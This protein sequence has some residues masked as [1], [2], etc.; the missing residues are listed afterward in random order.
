MWDLFPIRDQTCSPLKH[1]V[2]TGKCQEILALLFSF[3]YVKC[4]EFRNN[5]IGKHHSS[6]S[7]VGTSSFLMFPSHSFDVPQKYLGLF[8]SFGHGILGPQP[9]NKLVPS[10]MLGSAEWS[11]YVSGMSSDVSFYVGS[12]YGSIFSIEI[13]NEEFAH[14]DR[15]GARLV[16]SD[17]EYFDVREDNDT[18]CI[19]G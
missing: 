10:A 18:K 7:A 3:L 17:D 13:E 8:L 2:L 14:H 6:I 4:L 19:I 9:G 16:E 11:L 5:D 15:D 12:T 1:R